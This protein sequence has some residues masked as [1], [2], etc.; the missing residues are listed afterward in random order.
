MTNRTRR[1]LAALCGAL[2][3]A[4][5]APAQAAR[6]TLRLPMMGEI[7]GI[8]PGLAEDSSSIEVIEQLF[9]GLTDFDDESGAVVPELATDWSVSPD[10]FTYT[11]H[12]RPARWSDGS[13]VTAGDLVWAVRRNIDPATASP[14]AYMMYELKNAQA[15]NTGRLKAVERIGVRAPDERTVVFALEH[16]AAYFPAVAGLWVLRPL[17]RRAIAAWGERWTEPGHI[18]T[19]GPY[20]LA[21]W[22][23]GDKLVL[24]RNP[25]YFAAQQVRIP[26]VEYLIIPESSTGLAMYESGALDVVGGGYLP[27]PSPDIPRIKADPALGRELSIRPGPCTYYLGFNTARPPMD[28]ALVRRAFS[29]AIDR[30]LLIDRV[31]RGE[32][33]PAST[34]TAPGVFGAADAS[35]GIGYDPAQARRWL[36][37]AGY[38]GGKGFPEVVFL[39]NTSENHARIAQALQQMW[40]RELNVTVRLENQEWKVFLDTTRRPDGPQIFRMGWCSDYPDANNWLMEVFHPTRSVNRV[41]WRNAEFAALTERAQV[42]QDPAERKRLYRRAEEI[43]CR[44]EAAIAPIYFY[45]RV[46]LTKPYLRARIAPMGGNHIRDWSF[47]D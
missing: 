20:R 22:R 31:I 14:Y 21:S 30:R 13:P 36:A 33:T 7:P 45:T 10:G 9:L 24:E 38:P 35:A 16:P 8:D 11:F 34:F 26:R 6:T 12:L 40:R 47:T 23:P 32:Q 4:A 2:L 1:A 27:V 39:Y 17:P 18:V 28:K 15:I 46:T 43:L 44:E 29:A 37:E 25:T 19:N 3:L 42:A 41:H 5:S